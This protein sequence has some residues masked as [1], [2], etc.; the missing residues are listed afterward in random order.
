MQS[1][2]LRIEEH[3]LAERFGLVQHCRLRANAPHR[4][5]GQQSPCCWPRKV[6]PWFVWESKRSN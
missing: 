3:N 4:V 2:D 1:G 6:K 5:P